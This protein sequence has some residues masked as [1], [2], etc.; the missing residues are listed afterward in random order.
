M[1]LRIQNPGSYSEIKLE[2]EK[3][4]SLNRIVRTNSLKKTEDLQ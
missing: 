2:T 4:D 3:S 1:N